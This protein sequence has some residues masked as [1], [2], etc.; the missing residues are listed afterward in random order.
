ME[1]IPLSAEK[2][3]SQAADGVEHDGKREQDED[4][5][6]EKA[7]AEAEIAEAYGGKQ[8]KPYRFLQQAS[9]PDD[10]RDSGGSCIVPSDEG[11]ARSVRE[12]ERVPKGPERHD[13]GIHVGS[14]R[15]GCD[16]A[17]ASASTTTPVTGCRWRG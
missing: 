4:D 2:G 6:R 5:G 8:R 11:P 7:Y 15:G 17:A 3:Y 13:V 16:K 14:E 12:K 10:I 1:G 9:F